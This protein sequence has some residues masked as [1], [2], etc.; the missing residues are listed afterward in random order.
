MIMKIKI[1]IM[2]SMKNL[3]NDFENHF[4]TRD[5]FRFLANNQLHQLMPSYS[6]AVALAVTDLGLRRFRVR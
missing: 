1:P 6:D 3:K 5:S 4:S 2:N